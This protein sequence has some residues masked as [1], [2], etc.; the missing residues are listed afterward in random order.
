MMIVMGNGH[1][2][3]G[4]HLGFLYFPIANTTGINTTWNFFSPNPTHKLNTTIVLNQD[5]ESILFKTMNLYSSLNDEYFIQIPLSENEKDYFIPT[6]RWSYLMRY[7]ASRPDYVNHYFHP[8]LCKQLKHN[9][10]YH[11]SIQFNEI[12]S[13]E[14]AS[15]DNSDS[16]NNLMITTQVYNKSF[17]C[18]L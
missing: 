6:R 17:Q 10:S 16:I 3:L 14:K 7:I 12:P 11:L 8:W 4:R 9:Q 13:L 1:S 18:D 2:I 5:E 15:L